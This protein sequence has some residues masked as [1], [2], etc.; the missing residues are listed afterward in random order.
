MN[1][2]IKGKLKRSQFLVAMFR[3][4]RA[5]GTDARVFSWTLARDRSI[6]RYLAETEIRKLHLGASHSFLPGWLN[7]DVYP[8][9]KDVIYLDATRPFPLPDATFD[10][11][12]SEHMIEH[13]PHEGA[14]AMLKECYRVLRPGGRIRVATPDLGVILGLRTEK[15]TELQRKYIQWI[16]GQCLP[17]V[18][19]CQD[20]FVINN[21]FRAWGHAFLYDRPTLSAIL[22]GQGFVKLTFYQPGISE[23]ANLSGLESHGKQ[24]GAEEINQ[25]ETMV[26]EA[27]K[28]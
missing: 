13:V 15:K 5:L 14:L 28:A 11:V 18:G 27:N 19:S 8:V 20:V 26:L 7:T 10:Y 25:F 22:S 1:N 21:A 2:T 16:V 23:D 3:A 12:F 4:A 9:R 17:G 6:Q 24:I